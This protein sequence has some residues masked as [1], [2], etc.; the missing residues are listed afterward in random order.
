MAVLFYRDGGFKTFVHI[1][2]CCIITIIIKNFQNTIYCYFCPK[3]GMNNSD[4]Y[5]IL[6]TDDEPRNIRDLPEALKPGYYRMFVLSN[7]KKCC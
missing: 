1:F 2:H 3:T 7:G 5:N 4:K 6:L